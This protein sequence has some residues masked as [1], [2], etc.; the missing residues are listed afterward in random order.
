MLL[1]PNLAS[2]YTI[3][4]PGREILPGP[5]V[6]STARRAGWALR[7]CDFCFLVAGLSALIGMGLGITM[8]ILQDFTLA[9]AHAHLNLLG[10]VTMALYGLYHRG[11]GRTRGAL[12]W[13]QVCAGAIGAL[14]MSGGLALY[15][16][17]GDEALSPLVVLG[18][19][20]VLAGMVL[21][22]VIVLADLRP[23]AREAVPYAAAS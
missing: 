23:T 20:G 15:L 1:T 22:V 5:A 12:G 7:I 16:S 9:P 18:S 19:L 4:V 11:T 2:P 8:G 14:M 17:T 21:F 13:T 10:W 3:D 6:P